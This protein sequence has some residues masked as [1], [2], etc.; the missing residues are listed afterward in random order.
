[1]EIGG[2]IFGVFFNVLFYFVVL[3]YGYIL[4]FFVDVCIFL[5]EYIYIEGF[6]WKLG[7]V[8]CLKV[9]KNKLDSGEGCLF[10]VFFCDVVGFFK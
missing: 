8:I 2:K 1:M 6:F 5:E 7:F 9:L 10:F 4:S 3:E